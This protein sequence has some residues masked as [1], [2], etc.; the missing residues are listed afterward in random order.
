MLLILYFPISSLS[1]F[2]P[3]LIL[4]LLHLLTLHQFFQ[5]LWWKVCHIEYASS[6]SLLLIQFLPSPSFLTPFYDQ[7]KSHYGW[8]STPLLISPYLFT[9]FQKL[10]FQTYNFLIYPYGLFPDHAIHHWIL[11]FIL[12][13][14]FYLASFWPKN[15][16]RAGG[17][18]EHHRCTTKCARW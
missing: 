3:L 10:L 16:K 11:N 8:I 7:Q 13:K 1:L 12:Q 4:S 5:Q 15:S 18:V 17:V 9:T 6:P 2:Y 14:S